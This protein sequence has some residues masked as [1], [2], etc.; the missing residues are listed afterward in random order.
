M[1]KP[2]SPRT[3]PH[4]RT[5]GGAAD[6]RP[7]LVGRGCLRRVPATLFSSLLQATVAGT[8]LIFSYHRD[9]EKMQEAVLGEVIKA[10]PQSSV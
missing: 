7:L 8:Q 2:P 10:Y 4:Q 3:A 5:A 9:G 6:A 1:I